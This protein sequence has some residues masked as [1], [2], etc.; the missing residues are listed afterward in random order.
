[1]N[2]TPKTI[3]ITGPMFAGK[4]DKLI[5]LIEQEQNSNNYLVFKPKL[6]TRSKNIISRIGKVINALEVDSFQEVY[7]EI[8]NYGTGLESVFI[9]EA[10]FLKI[11]GFKLERLFSYLKANKINFYVSVLNLDYLQNEFDVYH[12]LKPHFA[13]IIFLTAICHF[14][15]RI[16]SY[17]IK[18]KNGIVQ[19]NT[20]PQ[21]IIQIDGQNEV[22]EYQPVCSNQLKKTT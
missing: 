16:A 13:Q 2:K 7:D 9:D 14:T 17:T 20:D 22:I 5:S 21:Q 12:Q 4:S 11:N 3:L 19:T 18:L 8:I 15:K 10:Q 6:D 1:M